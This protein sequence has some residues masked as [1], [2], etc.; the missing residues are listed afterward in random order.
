MTNVSSF[1][2]S[3]NVKIKEKSK[4]TFKKYSKSSIHAVHTQTLMKIIIPECK[5]F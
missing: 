1:L 5:V 2:I 4:I 3:F